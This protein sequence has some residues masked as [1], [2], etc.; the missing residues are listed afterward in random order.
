MIENV[1]KLSKSSEILWDPPPLPP[2]LSDTET[3]FQT[4]WQIKQSCWLPRSQPSW[5][6]STSALLISPPA[7]VAEATDRASAVS[8]CV[9]TPTLTLPV[10]WGLYLEQDTGALITLSLAWRRAG[11]AWGSCLPSSRCSALK[12]WVTHRS[13]PLSPTQL[14]NVAQTFFSGGGSCK[15]SRSWCFPKGTDFICIRIWLTWSLGM[16]SE[17]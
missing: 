6:N 11:K 16:F 9:S 3:P 10:E 17:I 7:T 13:T 2:R 5:E 8:S 1:L 15:T 12:A 14:Q 4:G